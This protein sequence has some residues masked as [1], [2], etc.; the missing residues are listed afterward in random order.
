MMK[1][2]WAPIPA[3]TLVSWIEHMRSEMRKANI[4]SDAWQARSDELNEQARA[5]GLPAY[6]QR[7]RRETDPD[8]ADYLGAWKWHTEES[9]RMANAIQAEK[10]M[11]EMLGS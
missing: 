1:T 4:A 2:H 9:N 7:K 6:Q 8:L 5:M 11:R 3:S 10:N